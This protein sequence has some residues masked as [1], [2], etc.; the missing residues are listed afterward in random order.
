MKVKAVFD[1]TPKAIARDLDLLRPIYLSTA[2]GGH[3]GRTPNVDGAFPWEA[4]EEA[5]I[6]ALLN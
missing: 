5:R 6:E 4:L 3:F 2:T 1:F